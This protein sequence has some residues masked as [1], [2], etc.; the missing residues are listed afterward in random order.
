MKEKIASDN[1]FKA[2]AVGETQVG[3]S[4]LTPPPSRPHVL[5]SSLEWFG[6]SIAAL[7]PLPPGR[8]GRVQMR[9]VS[10]AQV[11]VLP[12]ADAERGRTDD[13]EL[14]VVLRRA[15]GVGRRAVSRVIPA[16]IVV[17][18]HSSRT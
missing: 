17:L 10:A 4:E 3:G 8:D 5:T 11:H 7:T 15:S 2:K 14:Q 6:Y 13:R 18:R 1:L 16:D 12:D 9:T